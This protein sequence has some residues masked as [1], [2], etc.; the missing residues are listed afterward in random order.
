MP[1]PTAVPR[2]FLSA[3][4]AL[5]L[6]TGL[7]VLVALLLWYLAQTLA[8]PALIDGLGGRFASTA[9]PG[10]V[11]DT[12]WLSQAQRMRAVIV[13]APLWL[14]L[15]CLGLP[16]LAYWTRL[17]LQR[18][19]VWGALLLLAT[20][21]ALIG[22]F[23][24][25]PLASTML[26]PVALLGLLLSALRQQ[27]LPQPL[28]VPGWLVCLGPGWL[29]FSGISLWIMDFAA[30]GP[31]YTQW[32]GLR[33]VDA[34]WLAQGVLLF[35]CLFGAAS[36][37]TLARWLAAIEHAWGLFR[38]RW[39]LLVAGI[40]LALV[41]GLV[42]RSAQGFGPGLAKPYISAEIAKALSLLIW[43]WLLYRHLEWRG[44]GRLHGATLALFTGLCLC[45]VFLVSSDG[46]PAVVLSLA[47]LILFPAPLVHA[48]RRFPP[49]AWILTVAAVVS[50]TGLWYGAL[51][52]WAPQ[53]SK[54][55][56]WREHDRVAPFNAS[57]SDAA[58]NRWLVAATPDAG[59]GLGRVPYCGAKA[60]VGLSPCASKREDTPIPIQL[61]SDYA[62]VGLMVTYGPLKAAI[63]ATALL[64]WLALPP[65]ILC[66]ALRVRAYPPWAYFGLWLVTLQ[67]HV[68]EAQWILAIGG[69]MGLTPFSGV[70][71]P[72][73]GFG[74]FGLAM[75]ALWIGGTLSVFQLGSPTTSGRT[76]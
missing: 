12:A 31:L 72:V 48:L 41:L 54:L 16:L 68:A 42:G 1:N 27:P 66:R 11:L 18:P 15:T 56:W 46:G 75:V 13:H 63:L 33:Q 25:P 29:L 43:A 17:G 71:L 47:G 65:I 3:R 69:A 37:R 62:Y 51:T 19:A 34:W 9:A 4:N 52:E 67:A 53:V 61:P 76:W 35:A 2:G 5:A 28:P 74:A 70:T 38:R 8:H 14:T 36:L 45:L 10:L 73:L 50:A 59:F 21:A 23:G 40:G 24:L 22:P 55:A 26:V 7:A 64:L 6:E 32:H 20:L 58:R 30:R 49:L 60:H 39:L 57:S 44:A